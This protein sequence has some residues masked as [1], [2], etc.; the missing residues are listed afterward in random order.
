MT[1]HLSSI[2]PNKALV[3]DA[4]V[5]INLLACGIPKEIL[6]SFPNLSCV[7]DEI[8]LTELDRGNKNGH[9]DGDRLRE[10]I[11]DRVV[12]PV[13]MT[14]T[15]WEHF[16]NLVSGNAST[17]LDDGEAATLAYC[18]SHGTIPVIDEKK[19]NR[20]CKER[21]PQLTPLCSSELFMIAQNSGEITDT[22]LASALFQAL[23][24]ARMRVMPHHGK[25]VV[26]LIGPEKAANCRSLP[27][28]TRKD[29]APAC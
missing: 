27:K 13:T 8:I 4:S 11:S 12:K 5:V 10:L 7:V 26:D 28:S 24:K 15:C 29:L 6:K 23:S 1:H 19:A 25:W 14:E 16:E 9:S 20:I 17:T 22:E 2:D 3:V 21:F 18:A